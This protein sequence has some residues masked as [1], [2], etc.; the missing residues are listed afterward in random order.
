[1]RRFYVYIL[2]CAD[3]KYYIGMTNSLQLRLAQHQA[4]HDPG[5][6]TFSRRPVTLV[7]T[8]SFPT[9]QQARECERQ[10]KG[11]STAKKRAVVQQGLTS[12][13]AVARAQRK[14]RAQ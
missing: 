7:W 10:L 8:E 11:W 1:M 9:E 13:H 14:K 3:G 6:F 5:S 2:E 12:V 4:G